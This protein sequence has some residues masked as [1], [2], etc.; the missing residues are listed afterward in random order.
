ML[1]LSEI[2]LALQIL[3]KDRLRRPVFLLKIFRHL[4]MPEA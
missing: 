3:K 4:Q 1:L 2:I